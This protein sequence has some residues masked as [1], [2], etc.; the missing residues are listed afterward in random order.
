MLYNYVYT[1]L[2]ALCYQGGGGD[3]VCGEL[4]SGAGSYEPISVLR[5]WISEGLTRA[6][7]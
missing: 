4:E 2:F 3:A 7:S 1:H 5:F 6:D